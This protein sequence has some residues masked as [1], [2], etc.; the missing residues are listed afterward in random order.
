MCLVPESEEDTEAELRLLRHETEPLEIESG[1]ACT[2][3]PGFG[4]SNNAT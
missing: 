3:V 2:V 1:E 4:K